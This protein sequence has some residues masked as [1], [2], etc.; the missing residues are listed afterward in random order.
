[1]GDTPEHMKRSIMR[2][3]AAL[4]PLTLMLCAHLGHAAEAASL[5]LALLALELCTLC[6]PDAYR[7]AAARTPSLRRADKLFTGALVQLLAGTT[8]AL[9][10]AHRF[11]S[12]A[13]PWLLA[14]APLLLSR[15][16][17]ERSYALGRSLDGLLTSFVTALSFLC[18]IALNLGELWFWTGGAALL[19]CVV[20]S[21]IAPPHG[22]SLLP[23]C[24]SRSPMAMLQTL[25][26]PLLAL[27]LIWL[28]E[29]R[30]LPD[31]QELPTVAQSYLDLLLCALL[32]WRLS[33]SVCRRSSDESR[34]LALLLLSLA[35]AG[36]L[37]CIWLG[38]PISMACGCMLALLCAAGVFLAPGVRPYAGIALMG[39]AFALFF[40]PFLS[41]LAERAV[42][43]ASI[44]LAVALNL[45]RA[46][47][48]RR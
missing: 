32:M 30:Q 33:R 24:L 6:A 19:S 31:A 22:F 13:R 29:G 4:L 46:F 1:M 36:L 11:L 42:Q 17:E 2:P 35:G 21:A 40:L 27:L 41:G 43:S 3:G 48:R 44:L 34:P 45:K 47:L 12:G 10:L 38:A 14:A 20:S 26:S 18:G 39:V 28:M 23:R 5:L 7:N 37:C 9:L 16:F 15:L 25:L 8:I